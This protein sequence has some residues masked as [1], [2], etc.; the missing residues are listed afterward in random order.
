MWSADS[1]LQEA[2]LFDYSMHDQIFKQSKKYRISWSNKN[3]RPELEQA[4]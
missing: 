2:T 3:F 4:C 1:H